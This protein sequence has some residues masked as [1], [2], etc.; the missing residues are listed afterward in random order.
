MLKIAPVDVEIVGLAEI[1]K[2]KNNQETQAEHKPA[3]AG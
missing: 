3:R 1:V 2:N